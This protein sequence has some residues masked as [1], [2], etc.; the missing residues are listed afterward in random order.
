MP[1][2][3]LIMAGIA[4]RSAALSAPFALERP[5]AL[6]VLSS[7]GLVNC[8]GRTIAIPMISVT[9]SPRALAALI[10]ATSSGAEPC[11]FGCVRSLKMRGELTIADCSGWASGILM[12]SMRKSAELGF[13]SGIALTQPDIS[14]GDRGGD[15]PEM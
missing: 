12:T 5:L 6:A 2:I 9:N 14:V 7:S 11:V 3:F 4:A 13:C 15:E 10:M 8:G 1:T